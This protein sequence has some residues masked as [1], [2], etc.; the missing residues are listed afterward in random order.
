MS[1][2]QRLFII[3]AVVAVCFAFL[4]PTIRWYFVIPR[5]ERSLALS[6][7]EQIREYASQKAQEDLQSL[8]KLARSGEAVPENLAF[9]T[10]EAM[11]LTKEAQLQE[12][13]SWN[14]ST[15]LNAFASQQEAFNAIEANC[16]DRIFALKSLQKNAIQLGIGFSG[17]LDIVLQADLSALQE[18]SAMAKADRE[19]AMRRA[20]AVLNSRID[21]FGLIEPVIRRQGQDRINVKI[22]GDVDPECANA[23][24][25]GKASLAFHIVD[26]DASAGFN[27]YYQENPFATFDSS[28]QLIDTSILPNDVM[29]LGV[30]AKDSFGFDELTGYTV[31][32]QEIGL[33]GNHIKSAIADRSKLDGQP[34]VAFALDDEGGEI[35]YKLTSA[36]VGQTLAI[37]LD[38]RVISQAP[39]LSAMSDSARLTGFGQEEAENTA[40][41]IRA[42]ALPVS[43]QVVSQQFVEAR[44][45]AR[46]LRQS[47]FALAGW[48]AVAIL[49]MLLNCKGAGIG[50]FAAQSLNVYFMFSIFSALGFTLSL[51]G[52]A[53]CIIAIGMSVNANIIIIER[54][55]VG[56]RHA[57][58]GEGVADVGFERAFRAIMGMGAATFATALFIFLLGYGPIQDLAAALAIG[59]L[60]SA[61]TTLFVFRLSINLRSVE[62]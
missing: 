5:I 30:Y 32:K 57:K 22:P 13:A 58:I 14:A 40:L 28:H 45:G 52:I 42:A 61:F 49:F 25:M 16:R 10:K 7:R 46:A 55:K 36:N 20:L 48:F 50:A 8:M 17:G 29:V 62:A 43:L 34:E 18:G 2:R 19:D 60:S 56:L 24:I 12:P 47:M 38:G 31:V 27:K 9:L 11:R 3:L 44:M 26:K 35:F 1:K 54:M 59:S 4:L 6:S 51:P 39:I 33:D 41:V 15:V 37:V 23:M 53:G 21:K